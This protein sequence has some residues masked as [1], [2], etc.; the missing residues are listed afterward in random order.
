MLQSLGSGLIADGIVNCDR[1]EE[2]GK[3]IQKKLDNIPVSEAV[4]K[5]KTKL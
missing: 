4:I 5:R 1:A 3:L 2:I